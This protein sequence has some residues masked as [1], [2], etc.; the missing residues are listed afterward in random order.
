MTTSVSKPLFAPAFAGLLAAYFLVWV[1]LPWLLSGSYPLDVVE[2]LYWG[3]EWQWG[4][5]KHPPASSWLL[6]G[7]YRLFGS[8]GPYLLSQLCIM[9]TLY[10]VYR[11]GRELLPPVQA[12]LGSVLLLAVF[13]Y[14]WPSLEFNHNL[15][16]LPV[17]AALVYTLWRAQHS[18]RLG[19]WLLFGLLAGIGMLVKYTV[20]VLLV[21]A[22]LYS[23]LPGVR[24]H[25]RTA[26]PWLA[27]L[28]ALAVF[29][30]NL[31]WLWQ[32]DWLPFAY[33]QTRAAEAG[34]SDGRFSSLAFAAAQLLN[35][36]P[37]CLIVLACRLR[38]QR[39]HTTAVEGRRFLLVM[40][41]GP[42]VLL[43]GLSLLFG[44]GLRDMWG[45]PM[46]NLSGLLL[47][48]GLGGAA[49]SRWQPRLQR[50]LSVWLLLAS[51]L[52]VL[53]VNWG[54]QWRNKPSRMDWPQAALAAAAGQT[55]RQHSDCRLD[56]LAGDYWLAGLAAT[57]L[58][59]R[60][61]VMIAGNPAY[62]PWMTRQRLA[63]HGSLLLWRA[64]DDEPDVPLLA[65]PLP[66]GMTVYGG[67]WQLAWNKLP[68]R[69]PLAVQWR[70]YVPSACVRS[71]P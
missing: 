21:V 70:A 49:W 23:L 43:V 51:T 22:I 11:L 19:D 56:N 14:S 39:M 46:W 2:G 29:A 36:L 65:G 13:Y 42:A 48:S 18:G 1:L 66:D 4:Y 60:P 31:W 32:S 63:V 64:D 50:G 53:Y 10:L 33:A 3:R 61:S 8:I 47:V 71:Q 40:G 6:H 20:A 45:M 16:Q 12:A 35:H 58:P 59:E 68:S 7:F 67:Q 41:L 17:W 54:G 52:M 62:S 38:P 5:Y 15:A 30:P 28:L 25:W 57:A 24:H 34:G 26:G 55:W 27:L 44:V 9:A 69:A 37:L